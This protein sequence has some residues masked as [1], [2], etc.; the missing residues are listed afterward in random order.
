M[1]SEW[2]PVP[3]PPADRDR[4]P[5]EGEIQ[6]FKSHPHLVA[7]FKIVAEKDPVYNCMGWSLGFNDR[8]IDGGTPEQM[9]RLCKSRA[10]SDTRL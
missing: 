6:F 8:W 10:W 9:R 1:A 5:T 3:T 2:A 7:N 4:Q